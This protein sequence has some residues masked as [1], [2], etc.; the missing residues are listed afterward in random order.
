MNTSLSETERVPL[1]RQLDELYEN[2]KAIEE[3][4]QNQPEILVR[5]NPLLR[6]RCDTY[7][8]EVE[9]V[10][11][12]LELALI[13][14]LTMEY[15]G[16]GLSANQIGETDRAC[17]IRFGEYQMDLVAPRIIE[18]SEHKRGSTEGCL[19]C[20]DLQTT[21]MRWEEI[22]VRAD[23]Y[24]QPLVIKNFDVARITQHEI[25]HLNGELIVDYKKIGRNDPCPCGSKK[26]YK[27][28]CGNGR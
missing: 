28:C 8:K 11:K 1:W 7:S 3:F 20:P 25:S 19:S 15:K 6:H 18:H 5:P 22:V 23:N 21:V 13:D 16:V 14:P 9:D 10:L 27:R 24:S 2:E 12:K 17:I 26:K 4:K